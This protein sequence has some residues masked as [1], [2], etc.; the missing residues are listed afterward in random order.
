MYIDWPCEGLGHHRATHTLGRLFTEL[1]PTLIC[2]VWPCC[3]SRSVFIIQRAC[4]REVLPV[5]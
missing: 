5:V 2:T 1:F 4:E 3:V